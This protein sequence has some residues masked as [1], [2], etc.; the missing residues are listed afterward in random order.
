MNNLDIFLALSKNLLQKIITLI[1]ENNYNLGIK[2]FQ[3]DL[4]LLCTIVV[5]IRDNIFHHLLYSRH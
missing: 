1:E 4:S 5:K 2:F 3:F